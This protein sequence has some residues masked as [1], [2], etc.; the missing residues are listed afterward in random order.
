M[1]GIDQGVRRD[2]AGDK[3]GQDVEKCHGKVRPQ[4]LFSERG[5]NFVAFS[6]HKWVW[7]VEEVLNGF[8][9]AVAT[10]AL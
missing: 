10:G 5:D 1:C 4:A 3:V 2:S 9:G 6:L 7:A 8:I